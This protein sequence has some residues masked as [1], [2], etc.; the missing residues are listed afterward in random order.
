MKSSRVIPIILILL[1][2]A[3]LINWMRDND[4]FHII[5]T[6]PLLGG[7]EP[8]VYDLAAG[9]MLVITWWGWRRLKRRG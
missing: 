2:S 8:G 6:L 5:Q 9:C 4:G 3:C 7:Y 1:F